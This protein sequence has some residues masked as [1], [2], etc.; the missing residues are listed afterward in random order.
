MGEEVI[1]RERYMDIWIYFIDTY[2]EE[3]KSHGV[4]M[5]NGR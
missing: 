4:N 2:M 1:E 5:K 3:E